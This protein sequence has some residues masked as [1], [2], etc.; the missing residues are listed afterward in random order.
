MYFNDFHCYTELYAKTETSSSTEI[1]TAL[2][3]I[4]AKL[5][6]LLDSQ[7]KLNATAVTD[8]FVTLMYNA[9]QA[10]A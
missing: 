4:N 6:A 10:R 2:A 1:L 8:D 7:N 5:D 9:L 3:A